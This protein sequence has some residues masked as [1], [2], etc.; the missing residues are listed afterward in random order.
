MTRGSSRLGGG[1]TSGRSSEGPL[2][3]GGRVVAVGSPRRRRLVGRL[4]VVLSLVVVVLVVA[5]VL[6]VVEV[7][8]FVAPVVGPERFLVVLGRRAATMV[9]QEVGRRL[10]PAVPARGGTTAR[11]GRRG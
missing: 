7:V 9:G 2:R 4:V 1:D 3:D 11:R 6:A 10:R 5:V 8:A